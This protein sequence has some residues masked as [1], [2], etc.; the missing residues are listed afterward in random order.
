MKEQATIQRG[1]KKFYLTDGTESELNWYLDCRDGVVYKREYMDCS[2]YGQ[3]TT[4]YYCEDTK[5]E[6]V[7]L[8]I[9]TYPDRFR[10][11]ETGITE[12]VLNFDSDSWREIEKLLK[13]DAELY[14]TY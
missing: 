13:L 1:D 10:S 9:H 12:K 6:S 4:A 2:G 7:S 11:S 8:I 3:L 14:R 5:H